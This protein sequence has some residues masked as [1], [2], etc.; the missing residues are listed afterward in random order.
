MGFL[1]ERYF[2]T[3]T[4]DCTRYT[5]T[6]TGTKKSDWLNCLKTIYSLAKTR[7]KSKCPT[8][9]IRFDYGSELQ[10]KKVQQWLFA[11]GIILEPSAPYSQEENGV[12]EGLERT[13]MEMAQASIIEGGIDDSFWP[14]V[15]L[16]MTYIKNIRPTK[17][18]Q[19]LTPHQ[20]LFKTLPNLA[21]LRVLGSTVYVLIH[22][23]EW[24]LKSEKFV[25][26]ALKGKL[27]GFDGHTIYRVHIE[28][29]NQVIIVKD[30]RIFKDT[31]TKENTLLPLY[32]DKPTF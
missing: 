14:K 23:E 22:K 7:T 20:E 13:L 32:E 2:F 17:A 9:K 6:Y 11:E 30:L 8:E 25:P 24:E 19:G 28:E 1:G 4:D 16:A 10:S 5:K 29:Q 18:L 3:F 26:C 21:H 27:V 31:E 15:I 12:S